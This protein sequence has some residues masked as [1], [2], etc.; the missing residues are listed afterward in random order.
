MKRI[1]YV[2]TILVAAVGLHDIDF[3][4]ISSYE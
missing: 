2:V 3:V 1:A 4:P